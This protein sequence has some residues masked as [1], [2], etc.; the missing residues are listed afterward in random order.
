MIS[1]A[2]KSI[3][4]AR[5]VFHA[6]GIAISA[7]SWPA[8]SSM[9]T[10]CGSLLPNPRATLV[11][12]GMPISVTASATAIS[13]G[14]RD[15]GGRKRASTAHS[16]TVIADAQVPG[17]GRSRPIPK[18]VA[19]SLAHTGAGGGD[20]PATVGRTP[21]LLSKAELFS[22]VELRSAM[23]ADS[24]SGFTIPLHLP[25]CGLES[26]L[27]HQLRERRLHIGRWPIFPGRRDGSDRCRKEIRN[28]HF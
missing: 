10:I 24:A 19:T 20:A 8:T 26:H 3:K 18:K 11:A 7:I 25:D 1:K 23:P 14:T 27:R 12:A 13:T 5:K 16:T 6:S 9:T 22:R 4:P 21:A 17:P 2:L 28:Y 15:E